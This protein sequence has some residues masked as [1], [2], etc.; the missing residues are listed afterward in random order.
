M[1]EP[2]SLI[3][4]ARFGC[5]K[6]VRF[7]VLPNSEVVQL[8]VGDPLQLPPPLS[9]FS[10]EKTEEEAG[11]AKTLFVRMAENGVTPTMLRTQYRVRDVSFIK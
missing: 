1:L 5:A 9:S 10:N 11:L 3:P 2:M 7:E 4:L 6:L 8:A